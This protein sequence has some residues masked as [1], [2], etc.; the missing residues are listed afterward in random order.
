MSDTPAP[1]AAP[2]V[3]F[4][5]HPTSQSAP[6]APETT[7]PAE[8]V[9]TWHDANAANEAADA[10]PLVIPENIAAL[11]AT[12]SGWYEPQSAYMEA[13]TADDLQ[14][15]EVIE[16][17]DHVKAAVVNE[18]RYMAHDVGLAPPEL[19][20]IVQIARELRNIEAV[21]VEAEC[22]ECQRAVTQ[23]LLDLNSGDLKAANA[24]LEGAR[25]LL[26]RDPRLVA[27]A[28]ST[29]LGNSPRF[30][31]LLVQHA[32]RQKVAGRLS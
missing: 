7:T 27:I 26:R 11:R 14:D 21:D 4:Y 8:P 19:R 24:D 12:D 6:A 10:V 25:A 5:D 9:T 29:R 15:E 23:R 31:E 18:L 3:S 1:A 32:R 16:T 20:E 17:P 22:A 13:I 28:Q 30:V 2:P